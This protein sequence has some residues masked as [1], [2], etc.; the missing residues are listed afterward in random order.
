MRSVVLA[1]GL[2]ASTDFLIA[3]APVQPPS[4]TP[5][6]A[7]RP[8]AAATARGGLTLTITDT[9]GAPLAGVHVE[10]LGVSD[11][12]GD[13][14]ATGKVNF[15]GM[16]A[17]TYRVRFSGD[18]VITFE[19]ELTT[20]PGRVTAFDVT[21]NEAP[22]PPEPPPAPVAP[23]PAAQT[24]AP[25]G[26]AGLPQTLSVVDLVER[27]LIGNSQPR[28]DTLISCSGNTRATLVQLNQDQEERRY[29]SA[30]ITY[31]IVAG[32]GTLKVGG[33]DTPLGASSFVAL[34]RG[35]VHSVLRRG[36]RPL[37]MLVTLSGSPCEEAR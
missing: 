2:M 22:P 15:S 16:Q 24:A 31:Y 14:D 4:P 23:P 12:S 5:A 28:R 30:E 27:N 9:H 18:Q 21:L 3:Q 10:V 6:P 7:A 25:V 34:P 20:R 32:E 35:A 1:L 19:R 36:R 8:P 11:R 17:A 26:P 29:D 37:I 13:S 33:R